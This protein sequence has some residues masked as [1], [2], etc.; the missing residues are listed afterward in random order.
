VDQLA[1]H[2]NI[3]IDREV[4]DGISSI[5]DGERLSLKHSCNSAASETFRKGS[6]IA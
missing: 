5:G 6:I 1:Q 3:Y 2:I 4:H